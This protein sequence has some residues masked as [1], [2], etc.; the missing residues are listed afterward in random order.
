VSTGKLLLTTQHSR[1]LG[2]IL[3]SELH[4]ELEKNWIKGDL[5]FVEVQTKIKLLFIYYIPNSHIA[6]EKTLTV[7][8]K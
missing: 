2:E 6:Y 4:G 8:V 3:V 7:Y 1:L 5:E